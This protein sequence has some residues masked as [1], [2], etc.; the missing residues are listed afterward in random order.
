MTDDR[1]TAARSASG[2]PP[3]SVAVFLISLGRRAL[4]AV[5]G[6]L[7]EHGLSYHHLSALGHLHRQPGLSYSE[8]ARRARVTVQ[9]MQ[10]TVA[11]LEDQQLVDRGAA[12]S[13]GRRADLRVTERGAQVLTAAETAVR[14]VDDQLL[15]GF[16]DSQRA[17]LETALQRVFLAGSGGTGQ[18]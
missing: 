10:A 15:D 11:H 17:Q 3:A 8:L 18:Q 14:A 2:P 12:T 6:R 4:D 9:S 5:D 7:R 16:S 13:R 1:P